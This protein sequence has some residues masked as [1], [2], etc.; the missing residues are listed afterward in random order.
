MHIDD[1]VKRVSLLSAEL[2]K[3]LAQMTEGLSNGQIASRLGYANAHV[4][5]TYVYMINKEL[6]L[7]KIHS[8]LEKRQLAIEAFKKSQA[9]RVKVQ[10]PIGSEASITSN[11]IAISEASAEQIR[12][13]VAN[14]YQMASIELVHRAARRAR[15]KR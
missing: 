3:V 6:G 7:T 4:V 10:V 9:G 5:G 14:G 15:R 12:S 13:L 1:L 8:I 11:G 2:L